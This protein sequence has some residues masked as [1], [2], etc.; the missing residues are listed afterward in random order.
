ME[1]DYR[2]LKEIAITPER[3]STAGSTQAIERDWQMNT[4][5]ESGSGRGAKDSP[6][7]FL[8]VLAQFCVVLYKQFCNS[9]RLRPES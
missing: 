7:N 2:Q 9:W 6:L 4:C 5:L 8:S 1:M 3:R